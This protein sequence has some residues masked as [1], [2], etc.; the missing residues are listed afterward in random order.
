MDFNNSKTKENLARCFVAECQDGARYQFIAKSAKSQGFTYVADTIK[1]L[2]KN[3][4]A[5]AS[6]IYSMIVKYGGK[7]C[8]NIDIC[9]GYPF[10]SCEIPLSLKC[11]CD[12]EIAESKKIYPVFSGVAKEEGYLDVAELFT[13][14]SL[15]ENC[16]HLMLKE[17]YEKF[18]TNMLYE[19]TQKTKW[20]CSNCGHEHVD[21]K[22]WKECPLCTYPQG[23]VQIPLADN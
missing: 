10:E 6:R 19:T 21:K 12:T 5:H 2:A 20:K 18:T 7:C 14:I 4:M 23:Y 13:L 9:A 15:T 22:A 3:E 17:L 11:S 16:H 8:K 1:I